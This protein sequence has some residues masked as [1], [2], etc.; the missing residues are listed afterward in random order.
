MDLKSSIIILI[1]ICP[2][3]CRSQQ[4]SVVLNLE[5]CITLALK[6]NPDLKSRKL[7]SES[8]TVN[9][10]QSRNEFLPSLNGSISGGITNGRSIDPYSN[11]VIEQQL[12]YSNAGL[13]LNAIVFDGFRLLNQL[14]R[15]KLNIKAAEAEV[16]EARQNLILDVTMAYLGILN[17]E[18]LL[19]LA[20]IRRLNTQRQLD[21]LQ[22]LNEEG[23]ANPAEF[24][25][26]K[27]QYSADE[28]S[29]IDAENNLKQSVSQLALL[30][31]I[32]YKVFPEAYH[33][34][35]VYEK[36]N[37]SADHVFKEAV[38]NL[39]TFKAREF[40]I[41][42]AEKQVKIARSNYY[43]QV[44]LFAQ[45]NTNYSSTA[46]TFTENG[47]EIV[48]TGGYIQYNGQSLPVLASQIQYATADISFLDQFS[49]N[50]N[51]GVGVS[52][53]IPIFNGFRAK[54]NVELQKIN[55]KQSEI[56]LESTKN[57]FRQRIIQVHADME[58]AYQKWQN[59]EE[60]V[61]AYQESFRVNEIRYNAGA[62]TI[63]EYIVSKNS[64][65][66]SRINLANAK[67]QY[68]LRVKVMEYY[69]GNMETG[70]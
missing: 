43:P 37:L 53:S 38:Q 59:L 70:S 12:N 19:E 30:L 13:N 42:A 55:L 22:K 18:D 4:D 10:K 15:D 35:E 62:S 36:Y 6:N 47:S 54:N 46:R 32:D 17:A 16:Q 5:H 49:N 27:G 67:F 52:I 65:D 69:R 61:D 26:I 24:N 7:N 58:T 66:Q 21:R 56:E 40:R 60:Q 48:E 64:L 57:Q 45:L 34:L 31:N 28:N 25:N 1:I 44:G 20:E 41:K 63:V 39:A 29:V 14:K 11:D 51:S 68:L 23:N 50:L 33:S 3:L 9:F 8:A 2:F